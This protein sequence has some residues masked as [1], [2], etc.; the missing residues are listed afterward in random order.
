M[1]RRA[2][3][4]K[5]RSKFYSDQ[6]VPLHSHTFL[7]WKVLYTR[8]WRRT[9]AYPLRAI[10]DHQDFFS[11]QRSSSMV[12]CVYIRRND[13]KYIGTIQVVCNFP[14]SALA[15]LFQPLRLCGLPFSYRSFGFT[16]SYDSAL[17][18]KANTKRRRSSA[19]ITNVHRLIKWRERAC[20]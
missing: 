7:I 13:V 4:R 5:L 14:P 12:V 15:A 16:R 1:I 3:Y 18:A 2:F 11:V 6:T 10:Y 9:R 8:G 17:S 20:R 19:S